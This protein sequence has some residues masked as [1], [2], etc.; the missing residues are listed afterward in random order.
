LKLKKSFNFVGHKLLGHNE[1]FSSLLSL[2]DK[3]IRI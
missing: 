3:D 2:T 1:V